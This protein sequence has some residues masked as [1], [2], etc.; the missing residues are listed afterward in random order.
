MLLFLFIF[1]PLCLILFFLPA[2]YIRFLSFFWCWNQTLENVIIPRIRNGKISDH[3]VRETISALSVGR[4]LI[5]QSS[6]NERKKKMTSEMLNIHF[7]V[8]LE[9]K[10]TKNTLTGTY[11]IHFQWTS[12]NN[13]VKLNK[14]LFI[15]VLNRLVFFGIIVIE[16]AYG[17]GLHSNIS[18]D[19]SSI[20]IW[21]LNSSKVHKTKKA[22]STIELTFHGQR[23]HG[24][25]SID[26]YSNLCHINVMEV[27]LWVVNLLLLISYRS[28]HF[29]KRSS[30]F[31][32]LFKCLIKWS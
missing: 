5:T 15:W 24:R 22:K 17:N 13:N 18:S 1:P 11:K 26:F 16:N 20:L 25:Y 7:L 32:F 28:H 9:H 23:H 3:K 12:I 6:G 4:I 30:D 8:I 10:S 31:W 14:R 19:S 21:C 27:V 2:I 29:L